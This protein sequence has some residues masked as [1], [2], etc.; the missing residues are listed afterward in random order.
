[1][2]SSSPAPG[3]T[4]DRHVN[5][6]VRFFVVIVAAARSKPQSFEIIS[7]EEYSIAKS[8]RHPTF[9]QFVQRSRSYILAYF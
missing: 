2:R 1:V 3:F 5:R 4:R 8:R 6:S 9:L 7:V